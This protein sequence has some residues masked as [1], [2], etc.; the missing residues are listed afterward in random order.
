MWLFRNSFQRKSP[1]FL[2]FVC[3]FLAGSVWF[4]FWVLDIEWIPSLRQDSVSEENFLIPDII[5]PIEK[6]SYF[7]LD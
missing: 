2:F 7:T 4:L 1:F 3:L 6:K 5:L